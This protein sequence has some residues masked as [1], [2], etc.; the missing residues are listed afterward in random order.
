MFLSSLIARPSFV[1]FIVL[2]LMKVTLQDGLS[3]W[4]ANS[5]A[6]Y[7]MLCCTIGNVDDAFRFGHLA[8]QLLE[9]SQRR[10]FLPRVY[11]AVYGKDCLEEN[12]AGISTILFLAVPAVLH[13][14]IVVKDV[15]TAGKGQSLRR[16]N[17]C[18][19]HT[20]LDLKPGISNSVF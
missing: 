16:S 8:L 2:K 4:A 17:L 6:T 3:P 13:N 19:M 12:K 7:G 11:A 14:P 18:N 1:P 9:R 15:F 10:E 5:F 20:A